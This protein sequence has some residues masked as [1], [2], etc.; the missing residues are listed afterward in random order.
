MDIVATYF[1]GKK[2]LKNRHAPTRIASGLNYYG[3]RYYDPVT[4]RWP[5]RDPI[6]ESGGINL[7]GFVDNDGINQNDYLGNVPTKV[8]KYLKDE[9][10]A[11]VEIKPLAE[12]QDPE[13]RNKF[14]IHGSP[15]FADFEQ[16][17][18]SVEV[19][20]HE[21]GNLKCCLKASIKLGPY[22]IYI[23]NG[24]FRNDK[25]RNPITGRDDSKKDIIGHEQRHIKAYQNRVKPIVKKLEAEP[26]CYLTSEAAKKAAIK[27][28]SDYQDELGVALD[29][30]GKHTQDGS[31]TPGEGVPFPPFPKA[32]N[33]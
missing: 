29:K 17:L 30:E 24:M 10:I 8:D 5:S 11:N 18:L 20:G 7:Y 6:G 28:E 27:L 14:A 12:M 21:G 26:T 16:G 31:G 9:E 23:S 4:G 2:H 25:W 19:V 1:P 32:P 13:K 15:G 3:Y 22:V 33:N